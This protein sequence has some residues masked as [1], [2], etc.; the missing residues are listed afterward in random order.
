MMNSNNLEETKDGSYIFWWKT[1]EKTTLV[2]FK[3]LLSKSNYR[4]VDGKESRFGDDFKSLKY[5]LLK[6]GEKE[7][8][9][10]QEINNIKEMRKSFERCIRKSIE[11]YAPVNTVLWKVEFED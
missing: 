11:R 4:R 1:D 7:S 6:D 10:R 9:V 5:F 2:S 8:E 3:Y